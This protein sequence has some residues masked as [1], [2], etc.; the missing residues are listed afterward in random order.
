[1]MNSSSPTTVATAHHERMAG[2]T[3]HCQLV[4]IEG[5]DMGR[6][7]PVEDN[8]LVVGTASS[9]S[10]V[11]TDERVS[12][13][14]LRITRE[15]G[16]F[17]VVDLGSR[18][19]TLYEGSLISESKVSAG[20]T[21]K[22]GR[23]YLR[24]QPQPQALEV[25]PSQAR[26]FGELVAESLIM[27]E[28]FAILEHVA[29]SDVTVLLEGETGTGKELA[30]RA[31][32]ESGP[33]RRGAFVAMDCGALPPTLLESEFFGHVRGAFTGAAT[34]RD[35]A[36]VR[37]DQGTLFLDELGHIP[38]EAQARLLRAIETRTIRAVGADQ[39]R[40]VDVRI[41]AASQIDLDTL[42]AEG[43]FRPDLYYR[44]SV[45]RLHLP[46][47]RERREDLVPLVSELLRRRGF[48]N[49]P[50]AG[51]N[52]DRLMTYEWPGNVRELRNVIDRAIA[53]SPGANTFQELRLSIRPNFGKNPLSIRT[54]LLYAEAK[55]Q[56]VDAFELAYFSDIFQRVDGNIS[57]MAREVKMDRK[58]LRSLLRRHGIVD[59]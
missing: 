49:S 2:D 25:S 14:H 54:D 46:A 52:L 18:N 10:L 42:V 33:R 32:H 34:Q 38:L 30:A 41:L 53:L 22:L 23:T 40:E 12:S 21:F 9:C 37:A 19:G 51:T 44:L 48:A 39:E 45:I 7:V 58:Y 15:G 16:W 59:G 55:Q 47:L 43:K 5:P 31:I 6:A 13:Q 24:I 27:R 35:G 28:V 1:M 26:R 11:L 56:I 50:V 17:V 4:V 57:A 20:A 29:S 3:S 8:P 36:F